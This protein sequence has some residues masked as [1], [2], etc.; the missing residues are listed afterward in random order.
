MTET[1]WDDFIVGGEDVGELASGDFFEP[2]GRKPIAPGRYLSR[3]RELVPGLTN[4]GN[5]K[6]SVKF[7]KES[8][9]KLDGS[10]VREFPPYEDLYFHKQK[11]YDGTGEISTAGRYLR[12]CG[13]DIAAFDALE[14]DARKKAIAAAFAE[15]ANT[16]LVVIVGWE[17][18]FKELGPDPS[19]KTDKN[20][21]V[22]T[23]RPKKTAFF[24]NPD[25]SYT[26]QKKVDGR[27]FTARSRV[28]GYE[29]Y[30]G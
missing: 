12:A 22:Y 11:S 29:P 3:S 26:H 20:G 8:F 24:K 16:P 14:P 1:T 30:K 10:T 6:V 19:G 25:G 18:N 4:S 2:E 13:V 28:A 27:V 9:T 21:K 5:P 7:S 17:Q 23:E 15:H